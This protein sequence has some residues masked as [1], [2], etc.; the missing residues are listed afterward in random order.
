MVQEP[1]KRHLQFWWKIAKDFPDRA[2]YHI[3][4]HTRT[5]FHAGQYRGRWT[6][7]EDKKLLE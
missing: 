7:E 5:A 2:L 1:I 4:R 3:A 6:E